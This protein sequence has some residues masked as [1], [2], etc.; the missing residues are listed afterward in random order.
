MW[1]KLSLLQI[2]L[3]VIYD[4]AHGFGVNYKGPLYL[5]TA[6]LVPVKVQKALN[7]GNIFPRRYFYPSLNP[8]NYVK[9]TEM[10]NS[11]D[12][13]KKIICLPSYKGG[14]ERV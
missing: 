7:K 8:I 2:S 10:K 11:E 3:K 4:A 14:H 6:M 13:A 1:K 9:F 5:T 12:V